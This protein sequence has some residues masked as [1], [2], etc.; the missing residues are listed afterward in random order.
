VGPQTD[1]IR[2]DAAAGGIPTLLGNQLANYYNP[3]RCVPVSDLP[4]G[5]DEQ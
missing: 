4:M 3:S 1:T 2:H 5:H